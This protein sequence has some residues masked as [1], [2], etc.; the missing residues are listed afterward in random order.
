MPSDVFKEIKSV[1]AP[2]ANAPKSNTSESITNRRCVSQYQIEYERVKLHL[3][4]STRSKMCRRLQQMRPNLIWVRQ[5]RIE[6]IE[7]DQ[8][9][10][11]QP[12]TNAPKSNICE[13]IS[14]QMHETRSNVCRSLQQTRQNLMSVSLSI[15][16]R[17]YHSKRIRPDQMCCSSLQ[18]MRPN[19]EVGGWGRD[20]KK[21]TG[22][23]WGM[24]SGTI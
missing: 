14:K 8:I 1:Q 23:D 24:G 10:T 15:S 19:R 5:D 4:Y 2:A 17:L 7:P 22:R 16:V 12:A 13:S 20:P 3:M 6:C 11:Q 21:C 9:D 18:H